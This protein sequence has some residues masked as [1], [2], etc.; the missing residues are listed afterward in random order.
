MSIPNISFHG[1]IRK[2]ILS[3]YPL[4]SGATIQ[5]TCNITMIS[6]TMRLS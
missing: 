4:L 1:K 3:E 2:K 5:N 6:N